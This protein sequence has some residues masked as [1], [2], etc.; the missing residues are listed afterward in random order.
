MVTKLFTLCL[1]LTISALYLSAN[2]PRRNREEPAAQGLPL[3]FKPEPG[4]N[5]RLSL[6]KNKIRLQI[7]AEKAV[8][9]GEIESEPGPAG[10]KPILTADFNFDGVTDFAVLDGNG[11][12]GVNMFYR[13]YLWE[14]GQLRFREVKAPISNPVLHK[15]LSMIMSAQR[16]GPRWYQTLYRVVQG[17]LYRYADA[18][19]LNAPELW[20]LVFLDAQG[21]PGKR[22]VVT[23]EWLDNPAGAVKVAEVDYS[24]SLCN[25]EKASAKGTVDKQKQRVQVLDFREEGAEVQIQQ[26]G[27]TEAR[28]VSAECVVVK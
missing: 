22:A 14:K 28:W 4:V 26:I 7:N 24:P 9:V 3:S 5:V 13:V 18:Q 25:G 19:M 20:G 15:D 2:S 23:A 6:K 10:N 11:Y 12:N 16:S 8:D 21:K 27:K 17:E 1:V